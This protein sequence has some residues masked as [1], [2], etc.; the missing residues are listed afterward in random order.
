MPDS[1]TSK[2]PP[3]LTVGLCDL[4]VSIA[5]R[6]QVGYIGK[7]VEKIVNI[8]PPIFPV[9]ADFTFS[10]RIDHFL[11]RWGFRRSRHRVMPGL[12]KMGAATSDS[13]V[14]VT[15]NYTLSFDALRVSIKGMAAYILVLDTKGIN[16]WCAAG[17][18]TFG[19]DELVNRI[20][21]TCLIDVVR[22]HILILPQLGAPGVSAHEVR[23]RSGFHVEYG[24]VRASDLPEY[25]KN[26]KASPD[27]RLVHFNLGDRLTLIPVEL[28]H[29]L[30]PLIAIGLVFY[31]F[32]NLFNALMVVSVI[33][34]GV[35]L[36]PALLPWIPGRDFS[37]KGFFL[38]AAVVL[39]FMF[40][41]IITLLKTPHPIS[42]WQEIL[43]MSAFM[44]ALPPVTGFIALNFTGATTFTSR[45]GVRREI[46]T[47]VPIMAWSFCGGVIMLIVHTILQWVRG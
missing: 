11:A 13:P 4:K 27:M 14:F 42:W 32:G 19:T 46:F 29:V 21:K 10:N 24:P 22:H 23:K 41:S 6:L 33:L 38:G 40:V 26:R 16:V 3:S 36:F 7:M 34:A 47:Y 25:M 17:K 9:T 28:V 12:Y 30:L 37:L 43:K 20:E 31:W 18:G 2:P 8:N 39:I 15:G 35:V 5:I 44:L 45:T 1:N